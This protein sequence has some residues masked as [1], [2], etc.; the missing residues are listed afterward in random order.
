MICVNTSKKAKLWNETRETKT[1]EIKRQNN[2]NNININDNTND[3]ISVN[4]SKNV[5]EASTGHI[6]CLTTAEIQGKGMLRILIKGT[7]SIKYLGHIGPLDIES[8]YNMKEFCNW[9]NFYFP[10]K[11]Y[12]DSNNRT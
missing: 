7:L 9:A 8:I 2:D 12:L 10:E 4:I 6:F 1:N 5:E 11:K 3:S